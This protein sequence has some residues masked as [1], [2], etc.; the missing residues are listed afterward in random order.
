MLMRR[1]HVVFGVAMY[2]VLW[3]AMWA[4]VVLWVL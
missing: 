4:T 3:A 1:A 2:A